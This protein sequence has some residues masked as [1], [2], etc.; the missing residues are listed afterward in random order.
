MITIKKLQKGF[1]QISNN[2]I[3]DRNL[4]MQAIGLFCYIW[5][6]PDDW[7]YHKNEIMK[8]FNCGKNALTTAIDSLQEN[9]YLFIATTRG[10]DGKFTK[11][12]WYLSDE[13]KPK[14]QV[15]NV[16]AKKPNTEKPHTEKPQAEN[17][18]LLIYNNTNTNIS[19]KENNIY[20]D[21]FQEFYN[22]YPL[23][24][25]KVKGNKASSEK[26]YNLLRKNGVSKED[27]NNALANYKEEIKANSWQQT[28]RVEFWLTKWETYQLTDSKQELKQIENK[29]KEIEPLADIKIKDKNIIIILPTF[30]SLRLNK[31]IINKELMPLCNNIGYTTQLT[32]N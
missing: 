13:G 12:I 23:Q 7:E 26:K 19:N 17:Q 18:P 15:D 6:K 25:T 9:N 16:F 4:S 14:E 3:N 31:E 10:E 27:L 11:S 5:S 8:R 1:T 24:G 32:N 28:K 21:D 22:N 29:L 30:D 2:L 20:G